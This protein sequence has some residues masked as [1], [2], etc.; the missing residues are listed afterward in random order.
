M[1]KR[2]VSLGLTLL[3][4]C[5]LLPARGVDAAGEFRF[6]DV[7]DTF[8]YY[9]DAV[10]WAYNHKPY[11]V[12]AGID[13]THFGPNQTVTRA[14]AMTFFWAALNRPKFKKASAQ[15][16]DV[17][18]TD[19]YYKPVM[20]ALENGVTA[21]T[22]A[23]HF[24]PNKTCNR[25][26]ILAFLYASLKKPKV[27]ISNPYKDVKNQWYRKAA[28][29]AYSKGIETGEN[30]RFNATTPCT[31]AAVV[32]YLY[33]F[34][35]GKPVCKNGHDWKQTE[36]KTPT[37]TS[38]GYENYKCNRC[39]AT[40]TRNK[41]S[42]LGHDWKFVKTVEPSESSEGYD[43]YQCSRCDT[44]ER[45]NVKPK[46]LSC[47]QAEAAAHAFAQ[48]KGFVIDYSLNENNSTYSF[49]DE[50]ET[51]YIISRGGQTWLNNRAI[52]KVQDVIDTIESMYPDEPIEGLHIRVWVEYRAE[53]DS[54]RI[55]AFY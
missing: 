11:Q 54:Y 41:Q 27:T 26:E 17:R 52:E 29:W 19:W 24:S 36:K 35:T 38:E 21:G 14:Q 39:G 34:E 55:W 16:V 20:W 33:Q 43:L 28:L 44:K 46:S 9:Y 7:T 4:L 12:T 23:T 49:P 1:R 2:I 50:T 37:C 3:L 53:Y 31:R 25:G 15:F 22:D 40:E 42:A 47:S 45:R 6:A 10:Y 18:K 5:A 51:K 48:S 30:G 32:T 13:K 8:A